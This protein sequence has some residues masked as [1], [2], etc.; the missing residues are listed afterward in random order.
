VKISLIVAFDQERGIGRDGILPWHLAA[1]MKRFRKLTMGHI[2][3]VGRKTYESIGGILAG[4]DMV[5]LTKQDNF[6]A[7][8]CVVV[9]S[10]QQALEIA[11]TQNETELF[12]I[13]GAEIYQIT[14]PIANQIYLTR[15]HASTDSD[16]FFPQID[17]HEWEEEIQEFIRADEKN[18]HP[19]TFSVLRRLESTND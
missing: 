6:Q 18:D 2:L 19:H 11:T 13:G 14:L 15:V 5:V 3:L 10:I 17:P 16:T 4:R 9:K 7:E 1:D 8:G 12:V